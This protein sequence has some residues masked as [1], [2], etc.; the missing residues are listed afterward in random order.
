MFYKIITLFQNGLWV[1]RHAGLREFL[2]NL[3]QRITRTRKLDVS[4][5]SITPSLLDEAQEIAF[6]GERVTHLYPNDLYY[7]HLSIYWFASRFV[8]DQIVLDAGCGD[9]YGIHYLAEHGAKRIVGIDISQV[10]I[11]TCKKYF[12]RGNL[13]YQVVDLAKIDKVDTLDAHSVNLVFSSNALEH[14]APVKY[15]FDNCH[16]LLT[17]NGLFIIAVP[18]V[19][20]HVSRDAN[21]SNPYHHNI[22]SPTQWKYALSFYFDVI[23]CYAHGL[24]S[25]GAQLD[26]M[27]LPENSIIREDDFELK[28]VEIEY[29]YDNPNESLTIIY[30]ASKL[31]PNPSLSKGIDDIPMVDDSFTRELSLS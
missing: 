11:N 30:L 22:W 12:T 4:T 21:I 3:Y 31:K 17:P 24:K 29:Y 13:E 28:Q 26:L 5:T 20:D 9:G 18:P 7:A 2:R 6:G 15:F 19:V 1:L 25:S 27:N 8:K 16:E 23:K 14:V 10:A